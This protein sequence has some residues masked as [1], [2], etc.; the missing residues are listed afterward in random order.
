MTKPRY[1]VTTVTKMAR[2]VHPDVRDLL[3]EPTEEGPV[4]LALVVKD[5]SD[6]TVHR[7]VEQ[8]GCSIERVLPSGVVLVEAP[9]DALAELC[10]LSGLESISPTERMEVLSDS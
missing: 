4:R 5:G 9:H 1:V 10:E 8:I 7:N 3:E 6:E 2:Y